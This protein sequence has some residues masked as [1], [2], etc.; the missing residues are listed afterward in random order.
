MSTK[1]LNANHKNKS[2]RLELTA[3]TADRHVLYEASVQ[4]VEADLDFFD[5]LFDEERK[6]PLRT[7]KED[8]CGTAAL[9]SE[10]V[11]RN[12]GNRAWGIDLHAPTL[13]WGH[14]RNISR[15]GA[16]AE[17]VVLLEQD[18]R[19]VTDP[20]VDLVAGLNFSY[21]V[22]TTRD[23]LRGY[24]KAAYDSLKDDGLLVL[25]AFGG[26]EAMEEMEEDRD[27]DAS[28]SVRG[29]KLPAFVYVWEQARF[30]IIDHH[31]ICHIHF[32]FEDGTKMDRA[33]TYEWRLW[34]LPEVQELMLEAG[35]DRTAVYLEGWDDEEDDGDGDFRRKRYAENMAGWVGYVVGFK[36]K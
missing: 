21:Q 3:D 19:V 11:R 14:E 30:N 20:K 7:L 27:V 31:M 22:F 1:T 36:G 8:F 9:A 4:C 35:F 26:T 16:D 32:K 17:R 34:T 23:E 24:L 13:E 6:R 5:Q 15:L 10:F 33:F 2:K 18:V 25:D 12:A 28:T 29:E